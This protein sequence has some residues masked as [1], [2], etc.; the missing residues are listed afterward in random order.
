[1]KIAYKGNNMFL[2]KKRP[3]ISIK[4]D[5]NYKGEPIEVSDEVGEFLIETNSLIYEVTGD[6]KPNIEKKTK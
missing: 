5:A 4:F 2:Y 6:V 1:M 3:H